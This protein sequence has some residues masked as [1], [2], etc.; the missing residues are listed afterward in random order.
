M[1]KVMDEIEKDLHLQACTAII[2]KLQDQVPWS[3]NYLIRAGIKV[4]MITGDKQ[5]TAENI[6]IPSRN[7]S[8]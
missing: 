5:E 1:A 8:C 4:W 6:G 2:D 7:F 3:I